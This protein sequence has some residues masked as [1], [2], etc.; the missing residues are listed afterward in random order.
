MRRKCIIHVWPVGY[1]C[2]F[3]WDRQFSA[4]LCGTG[5]VRSVYYQLGNYDLCCLQMNSWFPSRLLLPPRYIK[6]LDFFNLS[7]YDQYHRKRKSDLEV[8]GC[9]HSGQPYHQKFRH[10]SDKMTTTH[11]QML[12]ASWGWAWSWFYAYINYS[13]PVSIMWS[14]A[15]SSIKQVGF[16]YRP[17]AG[18]PLAIPVIA[19]NSK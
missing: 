16:I 4:I 14:Y 9:V 17:H 8:Q 12:K 18:T 11:R 2:Y 7:V 1:I 10:H 13:V 6:Q 19:S 15:I 5:K 3:I